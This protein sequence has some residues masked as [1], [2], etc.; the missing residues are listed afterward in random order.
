MYCILKLIYI[1]EE[2]HI[3]QM[4]PHTEGFLTPDSFHSTSLASWES[5]WVSKEANFIKEFNFLGFS[6]CFS[7]RIEKSSKTSKIQPNCVILRCFFE[8][9]SILAEKQ[10]L[11]PKKI[12]FLDEF[13]FYWHQTWPL[14]RKTSGDISS[15]TLCFEIVQQQRPL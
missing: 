3:P 4:I 12:E 9:C 13:F 14:T 1:L 10:R 11:K 8:V 15:F 6:C 5:S 7:A 2:V